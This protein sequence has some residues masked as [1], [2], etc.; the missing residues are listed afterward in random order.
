M[1]FIHRLKYYVF[2]LFIGS[3]LV[4]VTVVRH[5]DEMPAWTPNDR[6]LQELRLAQKTVADGIMLPFPD[7]LL[8]VH[9]R[10]SSVRFSESDVRSGPCRIY[11][12]HSDA[13]RMRFSICGKAVTL[14]EYEA[15]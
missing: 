8:N 6:V 1:K 13:E 5:R 11:Q 14:V 7:S 12:L 9:I 15:Q 10:A 3:L 4:Y 2:G